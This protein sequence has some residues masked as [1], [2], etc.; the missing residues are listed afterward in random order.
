MQI[1]ERIKR[2][3]E[4][5]EMTQKQLGLA[6]GCTERSAAVRIGQYETG[7]RVPKKETA[8]A[9]SEILRCNYINFYDGT[10]LGKAER[11]MCDLFWLEDSAGASLY[12]FQLEKYNDKADERTVYGKVN[13]AQYGGVFPP[14]A[15]AFDYSLV[16]DFMREWAIHFKELSSKEI[17]R[18]E[19]FEWKINWPFSCDD[20]GRFEP[21]YEWRKTKEK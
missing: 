6:L 13:D 10:D 11:F 15:L 12:V 14:V 8:I 16:N 18:D 19:Y 4:Y 5:R 3:R 9:L 1:N 2:V 21:S 20:G 7:A 17:S